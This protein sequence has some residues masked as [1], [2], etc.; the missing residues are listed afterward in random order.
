MA[1]KRKLKG[2]AQTAVKKRKTQEVTQ[3]KGPS[4]VLTEP[5]QMQRMSKDNFQ[6]IWE[7]S[8]ESKKSV[9]EPQMK[10]LPRFMKPAADR[11]I[12]AIVGPALLFICANCHFPYGEGSPKETACQYHTGMSILITIY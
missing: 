10:S 1:P 12:R 4:T 6:P 5:S 9:L 3:K 2:A 11:A 8:S 7:N